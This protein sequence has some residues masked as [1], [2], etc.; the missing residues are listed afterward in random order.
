MTRLVK[1]KKVAVKYLIRI[2]LM[3]GLVG[4]SIQSF[5]QIDDEFW[6]VVPEL[7][8]RGNT[9]GTPGTL[10]LATMELDATVTVSMPANPAFTDI[11]V[12]IAANSSAAVDLSNM[13]DVAAS[14]GITGLENKALTADGIN[15]F[16]LHITATNMITA[17]WEINYTAGSDLWTLKG[18]NGLG[19]EFYTPFQNSTFTFPLVPQA[20]SA[21]DVVATQ[22]P[23]IIT[24]DLPPGVAASYGSPVQ[25]VGAGGTHVVSLDQGETFSLFP[26]GLSGAIGDR[27]AGTKIT[28]DAPIAVS[29]KDDA[30]FANPNGQDVV[31][32][33]IVPVNITGYDYIVPYAGSPTIIYVVAT[34]ANTFFDV[35]DESG[36]LLASFGPLGPGQQQTYL[37]PGGRKYAR[38]TTDSP[39][40]PV[41]VFQV[42]SDNKGRGGALVPAIGCTG[43]TQLAFT[44][45]RENKFNFFII[46]EQG[47]EDKF[48]IDGVLQTG[49]GGTIFGKDDFTLMPGNG[50]YM[51]LFTNSIPSSKLSTGQHLVENSGGIFHLGIMNGF[52][53]NPQRI[54][55]GYYSDFGGLKIG[56]NVAG[57]NSEVVRACYGDPVQLFAF[58]GTEYTWTPDAYLDDATSNTPTAINLPSGP[59]EYWVE[60]GGAC[61]TDS[62]KL[63]VQVSSPVIGH[64]ITDYSSG[65]APLDLTINDQSSGVYDWQYDLGDGSPPIR[66][67]L[68]PATPY[69]EPP[70]YPTPFS[71]PHNYINTDT[72]PTFDTITLLVKNSSGCADILKK[73]I[74]IFPEINSG[75]SLPGGNADG[76]HPLAVQF[77]NNSTGNTDGWYWD[78]GD[79]SSS[80]DPNPTHIFR[81]EFGPDNLV[82]NTRL[83]AISPYYCRDTSS[84][85]ITV[86]PYIEAKFAF[87]TAIACSPHQITITD[88]SIQA[89]SYYWDF[90][91][92][93][94]STSAGPILSKVFTNTTND[95]VTYK[96]KLRVENEEGCFDTLSR[97]LTIY[98]ELTGSFNAVPSAEGCSPFDVT[99]QNSSTGSATY[100]WDFG[101]GGSSTEASPV[102]EYERS[103]R[104]YDTTVRVMMV[105]ASTELCTDTNYLD[106]LIHPYIEAAY[107][108][109][110]IVGCHP[111]TVTIENQSF[112]VDDYFWDYGDGD[113]SSTGSDIHIHTY[114]NT[115][116]AAMTYPMELIV[117]NDQGCTDILVRNILVHPEMTAEFTMDVDSGCHPLAVK[118]TDVSLN[119]ATHYWDF[120]DG[121]SSLQPSPSHVFNNFTNTDTTY[122]VTLTTESSD[123]ECVKVY[124]LPVVVNGQLV[125]NFTVP[126]AL[127]C[128]PFDV[129]LENSSIKANQY[130]W[131]FGDGTD[132]VTLNTDAFIHRYT[133]TGYI[134]Q[135]D[136]EIKLIAENIS[137]CNSE[138]KKTITVEPEIMTGFTANQVLGCH[139]LDV[140]FTNVS[141][142]AAFYSWDFGNGNSSQSVNPSQ[143]FIN[144]GSADTTYR[145]WLYTRATNIDCID[146]F[147]MDIVVHPYVN[148][149]FAIDYLD[150]CTP[151]SV[152]FANSSV[153]GQTYSW[154]FDGTPLLT[155]STN[156]I[157][158]QFLN[159]STSSA[160]NYP[161]DLTVT[162][163]QGCTSSISKQVSVHHDIIAGLIN[164]TEGCQPLDVDFSNASFGDANHSWEFGDNTSSILENPT[165]TYTNETNFD[166][167]FQV[168]LTAISNNLCKDSAFS[169]ITVHPA[170]KA[171]FDVS[172]TLDCSPLVITVQNLSEAG[173]SY[174][175]TYGDGTPVFT[176]SDLQ[177]V[178]HSYSNDLNNVELF[179]LRLDV[180]T[181]F[182]CSDNIIQ[183]L[184]V[185]PSVDVDFERD[186]AGCSPYTSAFTNGS[187]RSSTYTWDFGDGTASFV[188]EPSHTYVNNDQ[189]DKIFNVELRGF[190]N[191]G[192]EDSIIKQITVF[193]S[194]VARFSYNPIYQY[195]PSA[196]VSLVNETNIGTWNFIW[197]YDD[198]NSSTQQDPGSYTYTDWG[199]YNIKLSVSN[200][201][202]SDS[203]IH[204]IKIFPPLPIADFEPDIDTGCVPLVVSFTNNSIYGT[205]YL[206][207]FDDGGTSRAFE[208]TYTF[209]KSGYYQVKLTVKGEGGEDFAFH[210]IQSFVLP[211][212]DFLVEP[213]LVM[214][215]DQPAKVFNFTKYGSKYLWD[216]G[217]GT[218][219]EAKDTAHLYSEL[220][221]YDVSLTAWSD[222]GC[223]TYMI[224]PNAVEVIGKGVLEYPNAFSPSNS[225][226]GGGV[227]N[228]NNPSNEIFFPVHDGVMEYNLVIYNRWGEL[229]FETNDVNQGWDGY[230]GSVRC[231][232]AVYIWQ[233]KVTYSNG[234]KAVLIGDITLLH[235][236][237]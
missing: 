15:N 157:N 19:T 37:I 147:S 61:K 14:P 226:P 123:G 68:N 221:I 149:D 40:K 133:N 70:G 199:E 108:V 158:R 16:G 233:A 102:H 227:Y 168:K 236:P 187:L 41:Y 21:I 22:S 58:G 97:N 120:G 204:W 116:S 129:L 95:P 5:S 203:V 160:A 74:I 99:F 232:E 39:S 27:L 2:V 80:T 72:V 165:H 216:F 153:N 90:G 188:D 84:F 86:R 6:F 75:F 71:I 127:G 197:D 126:E 210:E 38:I 156:P 211:V 96:V 66:Y 140:N 118:F 25:N 154:S 65:C 36:A 185:Y 47:N 235:K 208:P 28:S 128:S 201:Q 4:I 225:G 155:T 230:C 172:K 106:I 60:V 23:T 176:V 100:F 29:V 237:E 81:N 213:S 200:S 175:W 7:S 212:P 196:I 141:Q 119:P 164:I 62:I 130:R 105:A 217:D 166:S 183:N 82:F 20:Y 167:V 112:G 170:P 85:T 131:D 103:N 152:N 115:G 17:Y 173:V 148:A 52:T 83:I 214:L 142:G 45:A 139:P 117:Q 48:Y 57:T 177:S 132:T 150:Q 113:T 26:I 11:I 186:S 124:T 44:R 51:A 144:I 88:Q 24:F 76:C 111:F 143:T 222:H 184:T 190:S 43:N 3:I 194:P 33:Q 136:Y 109:D 114:S 206:W 224:L 87:D 161:I 189:T 64:F 1:Y 138:I 12:N 55:Y 56:A 229:V 215:P 93:D 79:G 8:H 228:P 94:T 174:D 218:T 67:D 92:G 10:R 220:G 223:E 35:I 151:A 169:Q 77:A 234:S 32:D 198:G 98:P 205:E 137:G 46:V 192:C 101:D 231:V 180:L 181:S 34:V 91:D 209:N 171:K 135:Q 207:D 145:V 122:Q 219:Y 125:A 9:G 178:S 78:F 49:I 31:G 18:S 163:P 69:L 193:P 50:N 162:S 146:S 159:N 53:G 202:C 110:D 73:T 104:D 30:V 89:D 42:G 191:Y 63:T 13:I 59:H 182:G 179:E 195:F 54:Y 107:T 134:N 121:A